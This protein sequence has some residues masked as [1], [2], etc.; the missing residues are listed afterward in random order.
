M[1]NR[2]ILRVKAF[3]NLY[4]YEQCK[5]SNLNLAKD[6]IRESFLPDLNSM[7]VQDKA[8]LS[9]EAEEAI[10]IF[11]Q[12]VEKNQKLIA[13]DASEK[14]KKIALAAVKQVQEANEKDRLFLLKNMVVSAERIPQLYLLAIELLQ[15]FAKHV[16]K[17][18][19][20]KQKL[21]GDNVVVGNELNLVNNQVLKRLRES[22]EYQAALTKNGVHLEDL[23]LEI[24][25]WFR[26]YIKPAE[27]YQQYLSLPQPQLNQDFE[28]VDE[29]LKKIIFKNEVILTF[30]AEKDLNWTENKS[31][32]RSLAAKVLKNAALG[33][34]K[35]WEPLPEIAMNWEEDKEFFENIFNFTIENDVN[36]R[37]LIAEKTKNWDIER[38]AFT[39]KVIISM[40]LAEMIHFPSIPVK[41]T[42]NEYI[43]ISKT[44][45]TPKSKQF[46]NGLLDVLAKELTEKGQIR[47][48][49]RGLLDNK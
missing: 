24:K 30:F 38:L 48:S 17:E 29:L 3:Q 47:K 41:V 7:E 16:G 36:S 40:A 26:E 37:V 22:T 2:R 18:V 12:N 5:G 8:A 42:I 44:Y 49:G 33:E 35:P 11:E 23:E 1:L 10:A 32:V 15:A 6:Y 28:V 13:V 27:A 20:K 4:A 25:E 21:A 45:S 14:V 9:R 31:V 46:V 39:D 19:A 34:E 43:D